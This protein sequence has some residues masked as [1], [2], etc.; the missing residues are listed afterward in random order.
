MGLLSAM[1]WQDFLQLTHQTLNHASGECRVMD[2]FAQSPGLKPNAVIA[3]GKAAASQLLGVFSACPGFDGPVFLATKEGH[4]PQG[5]KPLLMQHRDSRV[6]ESGHPVPNQTSFEAGKALVEWIAQLPAGA[7]V[8]VLLSGGASA[9]VEQPK[10]GVS[11]EQI[12]ALNQM[13][14]RKSVD[15]VQLNRQRSQLS[16]LKEGGLARV[17]A[18]HPGACWVISDVP[19]NDL[20]VIGSGLMAGCESRGFFSRLL[21]DNLSLRQA[22]KKAYVEAGLAV[23]LH[24][25]PIYSEQ[26]AA[27]ARMQ[28]VWHGEVDVH[29]WGGETTLTLPDA[30]GL[31][32]RNSHLALRM[33]ESLSGQAR[34]FIALATD[35]SDGVMDASGAWVDGQ[36]RAHLIEM[37]QDAEAVLASADSGRVLRQLN[38]TLEWGPTGTNVMDVM[39]GVN[40]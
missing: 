24:P 2:A 20:A 22:L 40:L 6:F 35:G 36:T 31:G 18:G 26:T 39:I 3:V 32:G 28:A 37:G 33:A 8:L 16:A 12:I 23:C 34:A 4:I 19:N 14:L 5:L 30:P 27:L 25:A 7:W 11:P 9:L 15:I 1:T 29:L 38:Q 10:P 13:A 17:L 21:C